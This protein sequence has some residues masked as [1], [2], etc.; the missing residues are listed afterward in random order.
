MSKTE[1]KVTHTYFVIQGYREGGRASVLKGLLERAS[2]GLHI[3]TERPPALRNGQ[4]THF[5]SLW[6]AGCNPGGIFGD[7]WHEAS[8]LNPLLDA[9]LAVAARHVSEQLLTPAEA[10]K[11]LGLEVKADEVSQ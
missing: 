1:Y 6:T 11:A 10:A 4:S 9:P 3:A 5:H 2:I 7:V 8:H